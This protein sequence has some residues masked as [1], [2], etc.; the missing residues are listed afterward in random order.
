MFLKH[1]VAE[2]MSLLF[3]KTKWN[4]SSLSIY[5]GKVEYMDQ[6]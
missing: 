5:A 2:M 4:T 3:Y 1:F 6:K